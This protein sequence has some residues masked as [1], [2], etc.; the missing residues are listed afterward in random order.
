[1]GTATVR[2]HMQ[3]WDHDRNQRELQI[4]WHLKAAHAR[5]DLTLLRP[6]LGQSICDML[7]DYGSSHLGGDELVTL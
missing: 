7:N 3:A 4:Y 2:T 6:N 5:T 1:M